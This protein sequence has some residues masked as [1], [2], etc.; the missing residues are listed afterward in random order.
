MYTIEQVSQ[1]VMEAIDNPLLP[2]RSKHE[3]GT[4][5]IDGVTEPVLHLDIETG[6]VSLIYFRIGDQVFCQEGYFDSH[7]GF[8]YYYGDLYEVE[9]RLITITQYRKKTR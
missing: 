1:A 8:K 4:V 9:P 6:E 7:D 2:L 3:F 5:V